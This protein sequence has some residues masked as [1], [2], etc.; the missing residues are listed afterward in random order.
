MNNLLNS[1]SMIIV[2]IGVAFYAIDK[3]RSWFKKDMIERIVVILEDMAKKDQEERAEIT[4]H[5]TKQ[6][7]ILSMIVENTRK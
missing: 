4:L 7:S 6:D 3:V 2:G 5:L 1:P